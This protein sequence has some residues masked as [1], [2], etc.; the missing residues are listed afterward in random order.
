MLRENANFVSKEAILAF[1]SVTNSPNSRD[2]GLTRVDE[3]NTASVFLIESSYVIS[4][5]V[6]YTPAYNVLVYSVKA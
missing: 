5:R 3:D 1:I 2:F 4:V 6:E